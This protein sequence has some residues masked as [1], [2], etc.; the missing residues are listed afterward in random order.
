MFRDQLAAFE[1]FVESFDSQSANSFEL[2]H[3]S[4]N[5]S[6]KYTN[7]EESI[8]EISTLDEN[9]LSSDQKKNIDKRYF[10]IFGRS[11]KIISDMQQQ[12]NSTQL[13]ATL[14]QSN[15]FNDSISNVKFPA[16]SIPTFSGNYEEFVSFKNRFT[17]MIDTKRNL[18]NLDKFDYL[19]SALKGDAK[20][21]LST[22]ATDRAYDESWNNLDRPFES[23]YC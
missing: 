6:F 8:V 23:R 3:R 1:A 13:E 17:S 7:L 4:T 14:N 16:K 12:A 15:I 18:T 10:E 22:I 9:A 21:K 5:L 20:N 2:Q 19:C 11:Q